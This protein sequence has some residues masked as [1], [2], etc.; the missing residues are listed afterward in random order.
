MP[1]GQAEGPRLI[2]GLVSGIMGR[3]A[4]ELTV[5]KGA[6]D[7]QGVREFGQ[8]SE[9][10]ITSAIDQLISVLLIANVSPDER[11]RRGKKPSL[12]AFS[13]DQG[14]SGKPVCEPQCCWY[15]SRS[16]KIRSCCSS[17]RSQASEPRDV[18]YRKHGPKQKT[19]AVLIWV[20]QLLLCL[21]RIVNLGFTGEI[22]K[23]GSAEKVFD[24]SG[25]PAG[26]DA[27]PATGSHRNLFCMNCKVR[28]TTTT[29]ERKSND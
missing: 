2:G 6:L 26:D 19:I 5:K 13:Q 7:L 12:F 27:P 11:P 21:V 8:Y 29:K 17:D 1:T 10:G 20:F 18:A 23:G 24:E 25:A 14:Y 9:L 22:N 15:S 16:A 3:F 4:V 28:S